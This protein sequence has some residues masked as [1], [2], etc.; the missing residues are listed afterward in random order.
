MSP[1]SFSSHLA[2]LD[3][4]PPLSKSEQ[5]LAQIKADEANEA[6]NR[7]AALFG[8]PASS[9][10]RE[11]GSGGSFSGAKSPLKSPEIG[12]RNAIGIGAA[13]MGGGGGG[14]RAGLKWTDEVES[15]L[16]EL[17]E[18]DTVGRAVI[19]HIEPKTET[20]KVQES[21]QVS[22][23]DLAKKVPTKEPAFTFYA[24]P[25]DKEA[26][27]ASVSKGS[28]SEQPSRSNSLQVPGATNSTDPA[29]V[30]LPV[31]PA[32]ETPP[33]TEGAKESDAA[34]EPQVEEPVA[35]KTRP[36]VFMIYSCPSASPVRYRMIYSSSVRS[37]IFE[38]SQ[39]IGFPIE[40]KVSQ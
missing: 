22:P 15:K 40:K 38:A 27:A 4:P 39:R 10:S 32:V 1:S 12:I 16:K 36:T 11:G 3:A 6:S 14:V 26:A 25:I 30:P 9:P 21:V 37:T 5:A 29:D 35:A 34:S 13:G 23:A 7:L 28:K 31:S 33:A 8:H 20:L 18:G 17:A 19:L 24:W 2:H